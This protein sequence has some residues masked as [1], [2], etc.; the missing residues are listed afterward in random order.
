MPDTTALLRNPTNIGDIFFS[1]SQT[2]TKGNAVTWILD[3]TWAFKATEKCKV[4]TNASPFVEL[5]SGQTFLI[6][7]RTQGDIDEG[8]S[9]GIYIFDRDTVVALAYPQ[10]VTQDL[11]IE[12]ENYNNINNN[13]VIEADKTPTAKISFSNTSPIVGETITITGKESYAVAPAIIEL[14][15]WRI[16]GAVVSTAQE[17]T[18]AFPDYG[19]WDVALKITDNDHQHPATN[20]TEKRINVREKPVYEDIVTNK[21]CDTSIQFLTPSVFWSNVCSVTSS[22]VGTGIPKISGSVGLWNICS[23]SNC[24]GKSMRV[25]LLMNGTQI[26]I[27]TIPLQAINGT[28]QA[29]INATLSARTVAKTD[30]FV[31]QVESTQYTEVGSNAGGQSIQIV[32]TDR[33]S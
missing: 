10:E 19:E 18:H 7:K 15:E 3:E 29:L 31:L 5:N 2:V 1:G 8:N 30:T 32:I 6:Y 28:T 11:I 9:K 23:G 27:K 14:W 12:N 17:F 4:S 33:T 16:N 22:A 24:G 20:A 21:T 26:A 13:I 25:R